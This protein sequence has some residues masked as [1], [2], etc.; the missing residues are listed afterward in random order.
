MDERISY[1]LRKAVVFPDERPLYTLAKW[2]EGY[3]HPMDIYK[4][5]IV[6][7]KEGFSVHS[8]NCP[9]RSN[10]CKHAA[11][12]LALLEAPLPL[13]ALYWADGKVHEAMDVV[14]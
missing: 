8:C 5:W 1:T 3:V 9:S 14:T 4:Q 6:S 11:I 10:P 7:R 12:S 13:E 2:V